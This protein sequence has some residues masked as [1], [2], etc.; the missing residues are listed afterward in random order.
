M[1]L[2]RV[3][4][5]TIK[6]YGKQMQFLESKALWRAFVGGIGSGKSW[7]GALDMIRRAKPDR[8]YL[9]TAPTY[10][11]LSD[12]SF[13]SFATVAQELEVVAAGDV[14]VSP[15]QSIKLITG[16]EILFRSTDN[17]EMLRGPNLSGV[18]MDEASLSKRE[19]FDILIGR[20]R[21]GGE[22][23][24]G[25]ATF[26]PKGKLHWTYKMFGLG[27][28]DTDLIHARSEENPFLP[29]D[30]VAN[31]RKQY[32]AQQIKQELGGSFIDSGGNHYFPGSWP[33]YID[34]GDAYRVRDGER[35]R[36]I[37]KADCSRLLALDW[38]M[39]K[40][41]KDKVIQQQTRPDELSGDCTAFVVAD[42]SDDYDGALFMLS[43]INE[44]IP[45]GSNAPRLAEMC[46]RWQPIVVSG[47]DDNLS[48]TMLLECR[49][50]RDIPTI[51]CMPIRSKNKVT[52]SQ[53][54]IVRAERGMVYLPENTSQPWV[55]MLSDQLASFTGVD[56]EP[57]D[58]ADCFAILGRLA[59]E[60]KPGEDGD[61]YEPLLGAAGYESDVY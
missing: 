38:A 44:R 31:I 26:T 43:A 25:T 3:V 48:E 18:W 29:K 28:Q 21:Q 55:E 56:G 40:P 32:T 19:A 15:P 4:N 16:A 37:R 34:A 46:R 52:R 13:R 54:S 7:I 24:W 14:K 27:A 6:V 10:P 50:Y 22:M 35:W 23:G 36:H 51:K 12:A 1:A 41:K 33:T 53:A 61:V 47:D 59:D 11:M 5:K 58:M 60:F 2:G 57:D 45:M 30:F 17:P 9:V 39:G 49:R 20:L 8:L 42:M